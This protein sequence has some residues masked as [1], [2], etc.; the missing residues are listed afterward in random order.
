M[1]KIMY[2]YTFLLGSF[3]TLLMPIYRKSDLSRPEEASDTLH[4]EVLGF[5]LDISGCQLIQ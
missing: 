2:L 1:K 3:C 5:P 4:V